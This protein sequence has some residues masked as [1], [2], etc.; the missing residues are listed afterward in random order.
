MH[1]QSIST[2][3]LNL[4][5]LTLSSLRGMEGLSYNL[6]INGSQMINI[7]ESVNY[8]IEN[9]QIS[10]KVASKL[11]IPTLIAQFIELQ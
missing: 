2:N 3:R 7:R 9:I 6:E 11:D 8:N 1:K 10:D 5:R 4:K